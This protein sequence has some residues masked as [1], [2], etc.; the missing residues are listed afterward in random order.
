MAETEAGPD[1]PVTLQTCTGQALTDAIPDLARLRVEVFRAWPYLYEGSAENEAEYLRTYRDSS[2]A[3]VIVARQ[4]AR[5]V[6]ASTCLPLADETDAVQ[7]PFR[8][9]GLNISEFFYFGESVLLPGLRGQG[10]G[11]R[12]F[13]AREAHARSSSARFACFCSVVRQPDHPARPPAWEP[14]DR[15]WTRRGFARRP[16]L[17]CQIAWRDLG[18]T[19]ETAKDMVFWVKPLAGAPPS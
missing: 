11:V 17:V 1:T 18:D 16:D 10:V 3:A 7:A 13:E 8:A 9:G 14:L 6:G 2:R 15:F 19:E 4:G 5:I 12:F